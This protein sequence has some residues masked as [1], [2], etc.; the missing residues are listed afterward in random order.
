M[1]FDQLNLSE[2]LLR[3]IR[4]EGYTTPTPIQIQAIPYVLEG[5]DLLGCAQTGTGKTAAFAWPILHRLHQADAESKTAPKNRG[6]RK[7]RALVITPTRE[8]AAQIGESFATYGRHTNLR[9]TVIFGGVNQSSQVRALKRGV[10]TLVATPGRLL[11]LLNQRVMSLGGVEMLVLDEAD[12]ML[13]MGF[14]HDI[15]KIITYL[16]EKRQALLFSATMPREIRALANTI[17]HSPVSVKV[18]TKPPAAETVD[19]VIYFVNRAD[20]VALLKDLLA[21]SETTKALVFSR[22]KWGADK[23]VT[24]LHRAEFTA[25]AI[26]SNKTQNARQRALKNFKEKGRFQ[27]V[28]GRRK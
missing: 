4:R 1:Q 23:I 20:K 19:Q 21:D 16:P 11:D 3:A 6:Q 17:L 10:D 27:R 12:R 7:I 15:R 24:H 25:A 28:C 2:P 26:H 18:A 5:K 8:L 13:D 22:T 14:I 9:Q